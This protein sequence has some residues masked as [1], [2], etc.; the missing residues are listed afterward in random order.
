MDH[1]FHLLNSDQYNLLRH[2]HIIYSPVI[3]QN[4]VLSLDGNDIWI[5][6]VKSP[7]QK[8]VLVSLSPHHD[9]RIS[10]NGSHFSVNMRNL[11]SDN[12]KVCSREA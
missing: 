8:C 9:F 6:K 10:N 7:Q 5:I 4:N 11:I 2:L 1:S 3:A 12:V